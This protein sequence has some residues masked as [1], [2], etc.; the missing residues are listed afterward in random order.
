MGSLSIQKGKRAE[1]QVAQILN[2]ILERA[3]LNAGCELQKLKRNVEQTQVGGFDLDGLDWIAIEVKHCQTLCLPAWWRQAV[4]QAGSNRIPVL[5][6]K[7]HGDKWRVRML[8]LQPVPAEGVALVDI[9][10]DDF[11]VWF[12]ARATFELA[13]KEQAGIF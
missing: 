13:K 2:P 4:E 11:L 5:I 7:K 1:R 3:C 10:M 8:W 12:E 9:S 6:Y